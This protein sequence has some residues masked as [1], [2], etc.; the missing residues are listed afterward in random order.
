MLATIPL[1]ILLLGS[2]YPLNY[3]LK[4]SIFEVTIHLTI[5]LKN[6]IFGVNILLS[7]PLKMQTIHLTIPLKI[8]FLE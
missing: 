4:N 5:P 1:T 2:N 3:P 7:I 8:L 6:A